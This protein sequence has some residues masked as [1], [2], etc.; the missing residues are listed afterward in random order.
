MKNDGTYSAE[1]AGERT[2]GF[3]LTSTNANPGYGDI[4]FLLDLE[5]RMSRRTLPRSAFLAMASTLANMI[6]RWQQR[7]N[8]LSEITTDST[9]NPEPSPASEHGETKFSLTE[10]D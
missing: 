4:S 8:E 9:K 5:G 3:R 6:F 7:L 10:P 2:A 1:N